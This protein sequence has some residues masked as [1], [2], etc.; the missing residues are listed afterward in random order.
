MKPDGG[1]HTVEQDGGVVCRACEA[2]HGR[3]CIT[4]SSVPVHCN[5]RCHTRKIALDVPRADMHVGFC[6]Q[7]GHLHNHAF[8]SHLVRYD[9]PYENPLH[10][11]E[12]FRRFSSELAH[13]L[14][15]TYDLHGKTI[16][17]IGCGDGRFLEE[18]CTLGG[19]Q[20]IGFEPSHVGRPH[21]TA[22]NPH[23][24]MINSYFT[25]QHHEI[26]ADF[27]CCRQVLEHLESPR[28]ILEAVRK[29][30][31]VRPSCTVFF[32]VPDARYTLVDLGV[33]DLLYEHCNYFTNE[34]L[35]NLFESSGFN[36]L[37]IRRMFGGQ[38]LGIEARVSSV[39]KTHRSPLVENRVND[40]SG[41]VDKFVEHYHE[42]KGHW[43]H[44]LHRLRAQG[45]RVVVWG[46]GSKGTMFLNTVDT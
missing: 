8:Q 27:I 2:P 39:P 17:E 26:E 9:A 13:Y 23:V 25:D 5:I 14:V 3:H 7:C 19:N 21:A 24:R 28:R 16:A 1:K 15:D 40:L 36:V 41:L 29:A 42:K 34:S 30:A 10:H 31:T 38:Y 44:L 12:L 45:K 46:S 32:E 20:G 18:L 33:W 11:S 35:A 43:I 37:D 4:L 22:Q 6:H